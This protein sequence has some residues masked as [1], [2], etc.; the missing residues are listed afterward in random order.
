MINNLF[1]HKMIY[2]EYGY[3]AAI[4][5]TS[6]QDLA[7]DKATGTVKDPVAFLFRE[8]NMGK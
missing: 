4:F 2:F 1:W 7:N 8:I 5:E 6:V 3:F